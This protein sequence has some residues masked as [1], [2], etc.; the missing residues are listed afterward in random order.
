[1]TF[2]PSTFVLSYDQAMD[3]INNESYALIAD[4]VGNFEKNCYKI[5]NLLLCSISSS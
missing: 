4:Y 5:E 2:G 1:M 3:K